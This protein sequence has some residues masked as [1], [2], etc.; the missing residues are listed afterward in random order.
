MHCGNDD[1]TFSPAGSKILYNRKR[2]DESDA[3]ASKQGG[4]ASPEKRDAFPFFPALLLL[5]RS[6]SVRRNFIS[7]LR[8]AKERGSRA[9]AVSSSAARPRP[10]GSGGRG[11]SGK[12]WKTQDFSTVYF[13]ARRY[14]NPSPGTEPGEGFCYTFFFRLFR[15]HTGHPFP[16]TRLAITAS[17][18]CP[19]TGQ[20][21]HTFLFDFS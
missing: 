18:S 10:R 16:A 6:R 11:A 15:E 17:H 20:S 19:H 21:H 14:T 3:A 12:L 7:F 2:A 1:L 13:M 9:E 5:L 8:N 4:T